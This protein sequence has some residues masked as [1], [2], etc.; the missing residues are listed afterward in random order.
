MHIVGLTGGI[1]S[2]KTTV[3]RF[4]AQLGVPVYIADLHA[5]ELMIS[6]T[7]IKTELLELLGEQAYTAQGELNRS[8]IASKVFNNPQQLQALNAIVHPRVAEHFKQWIAQQDPLVST[9][10]IKEAAVL[11]ENDSYMQCDKT[12]LVT[13]PVAIRI[14]RVLDRDNTQ[15]EDVLARMANQWPDSKKIPLADYVI[16]NLDLHETQTQVKLLHQAL[17]ALNS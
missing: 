17:S 6:S 4:F 12:I 3:G 7:A 5:K 16:E 10:V 15:K 11:F 1:G 14:A 2:G 8:F 13:A 9:Y